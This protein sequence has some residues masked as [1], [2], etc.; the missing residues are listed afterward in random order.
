MK[1][2]KNQWGIFY[3]CVCEVER[4]S[5]GVLFLTQWKGNPVGVRNM[6]MAELSKMPN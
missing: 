5:G 1:V 2:S 6:D 4:R 3:V